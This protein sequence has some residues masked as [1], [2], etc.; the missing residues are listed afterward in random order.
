VSTP[1]LFTAMD[2]EKF[3]MPFSMEED[4]PVIRIAPLE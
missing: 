4:Q 3:L 1:H 2:F